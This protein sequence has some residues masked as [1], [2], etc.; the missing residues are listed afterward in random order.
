[1][2]PAEIVASLKE[3]CAEKGPRLET[4]DIV[5]WIER[6]GG[7]ESNAELDRL[8]QEDEGPA[9]CPDARIRG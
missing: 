8:R 7:F 1:M 6:I 5:D 9:V 4:E 2:G 3:L